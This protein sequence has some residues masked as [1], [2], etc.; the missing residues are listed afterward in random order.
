MRISFKIIPITEEAIEKNFFSNIVIENKFLKFVKTNKWK[1]AVSCFY[2]HCL[3]FFKHNL[4]ELTIDQ[5][6]RV[7]L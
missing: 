5:A 2:K 3:K 1:I 7:F 6:Y 4:T